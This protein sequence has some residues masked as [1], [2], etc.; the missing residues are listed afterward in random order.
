MRGG[1]YTPAPEDIQIEAV[2]RQKRK[3]YDVYLRKFQ[4]HEALDAALKVSIT[5][6]ARAVCNYIRA[7]VW[8]HC[9]YIA[10]SAD[11][12]CGSGRIHVGRA[13][14]ARCPTHRALWPL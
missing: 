12:A 4:Y 7:D 6:G 9:A 13:S 10:C 1:S 5:P 3:E 11:T 8:W 2:R 14:P